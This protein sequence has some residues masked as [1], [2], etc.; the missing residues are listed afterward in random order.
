MKRFSILLFLLPLLM[1][2]CKP[3]SATKNAAAKAEV[4]VEEDNT[5]DLCMYNTDTLNPLTTSVKHNAEVLSCLYDSLFTVSSDFTAVPDVCEQYRISENGLTFSAYL[6]KNIRFQDGTLLTPQD[7][8]DSVNRI[9][10]SNGYY[11]SRL[12][13]IKGAYVKNGMLH[14]DFTY[15][16]KNML[17]LLDFP[18]LPK[19]GTEEDGNVLSPPATGSG[20]FRLTEYQTNKLLRLSPNPAHHSGKSP[21]FEEVVI[22]M[23]D[24]RKTAVTMLEN[25]MVNILAGYAAD[26]TTYLPSAQIKTK[27]HSGCSFVFLGM[28][29]AENCSTISASIH[30]EQLVPE[31][32]VV[33]P[34]PMHP[35]ADMIYE[36]PDTFQTKSERTSYTLLFCKSTPGRLPVAET[37]AKQLT[38]AGF[39]VKT[40]GVG[41][42][43]Y[44]KRIKNGKYDLFIG[45]TELFPNFETASLPC[46]E[47]QIAGLYF[48]NET[49]LI[50]GPIACDAIETLNPYKSIHLWKPAL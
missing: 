1:F 47:H 36:Q 17:V 32:A 46:P 44:E 34:F 30:R 31:G 38:S 49:L 28:K 14:I 50:N 4:Y 13:N 48:T 12:E 45:E 24:T 7:A 3:E 11:K 9:V 19:G 43:E 35:N 8:A 6:R 41:K 15:P 42:S 10:A 23:A 2:G 22:H 20:L 18:I 27:T 25:G 21:Y 33:S 29:S 39:S 5:L 37:I 40:E 16:R 26:T